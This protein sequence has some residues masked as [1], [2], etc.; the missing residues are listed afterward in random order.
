MDISCGLQVF[1]K[2][3]VPEVDVYLARVSSY[4][5]GCVL[6]SYSKSFSSLRLALLN[7]SS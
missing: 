4:S 1:L 5:G 3:S 6:L 7:G 2:R